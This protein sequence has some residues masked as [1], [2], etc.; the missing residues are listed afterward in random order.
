M[1]KFN[2]LLHVTG[3]ISAF[4]AC[5]LAS[6]LVKDG[7]SVQT[8]ASKGALNFVGPASFEGI[9]G[10][11]VLTDVFGG[12]PDFTP[13]ITLAQ[14]WADLI[15]VYPAT[16]NVINRMAAGLSDDLFGATFLANNFKNPVWIAPGM[17]SLMLQ[18]PATVESMKKLEGWGCKVLPTN[19]GRM[20]CGT[21]G[22]GRLLEP[23]E[24]FEMIKEQL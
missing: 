5:S 16:A 10:K 20:A 9:T 19:D 4:K 14:E 7:Y 2:I 3:S 18:H 23:E 15:L 21:V 13:H 17:N 11:S 22:P 12:E 24:V 1:S 6:M 8:T